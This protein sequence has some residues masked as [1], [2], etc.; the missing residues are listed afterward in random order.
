[1][2]IKAER[3]AE[4]E[5]TPSKSDKELGEKIIKNLKANVVVDSP[6]PIQVW[7]HAG[8]AHLYGNVLMHAEKQMLEEIVRSTKGVLSVCNHL[9]I[10]P[11][12]RKR[13]LL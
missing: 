12:T 3:I 7:V 5:T 1:M 9:E 10:I 13:P 8:V 4:K 2:T 11:C 6:S